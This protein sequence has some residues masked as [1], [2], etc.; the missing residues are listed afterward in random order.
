M[1]TEEIGALRALLSA[2]SARFAQDMGK[3]REA[4]NTNAAKMERGMRK[5]GDAFSWTF[6]K[7][8]KLAGYAGVGGAAGF[9]ALIKKTV[10]NTVALG[11][12][13]Q[14]IGV[15][16]RSLSTLRYAAGVTKVEFEDLADGLVTLAEAA[17]DFTEDTGPAVEAFKALKFD[18]KDANGVVKDADVLFREL[19]DKFA[20]ME[21]GALKSTLAI[22]IFSDTGK[23][24][25]PLLNMGSAGI[26]EMEERARELGFELTDNAVQSAMDLDRQFQNLWSTLAGFGTA[27]A[28]DAIPILNNLIQAMAEAYRQGGLLSGLRELILQPGRVKRAREEYEKWAEIQR[29][30]REG[31]TAEKLEVLPYK[32]VDVQGRLDAAKAALLI[33]EYDEKRFAR[34]A[35]AAGDRQREQERQRAELKKQREEQTRIYSERLQQLT[36]EEEAEKEREAAQK[37]A[38]AR[39]KAAEGQRQKLQTETVTGLQQEIDLFKATSREERVTWEIENGRFAN[40][41]EAQKKK[42]VQ[43]ARELDILDA[44]REA[45]EKL[46]NTQEENEKKAA[47]IAASQMTRQERYN[48]AVKELEN[49]YITTGLSTEDYHRRLKELQGLLETDLTGAIRGWGRDASQVL[50]DFLFAGENTFR[51]F[52]NAAIRELVRLQLQKYFTQPLFE[53]IAGRME[54]ASIPGRAAGGP[55]RA[56]GVYQVAEKGPEMLS[57]GAQHFLMMANRPG[58]VTPMDGPQAAGKQVAPQSVRIVNV[59]DQKTF[60]DW[61]SSSSGERVIVNAISRNASQIKELLS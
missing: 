42:V 53:G 34:E 3:A 35:E 29:K 51:E 57:V 36:K 41:D 6:G 40:F 48:A 30:M 13:S 55:V 28:T 45:Q 16:V 11:N 25:I 18:V 22:R 10:D 1:A 43:L 19:A 33:A 50:T 17:Q 8:K 39:A 44:I 60:D 5:V 56:G 58:M 46:K 37:A 59:L 9:A 4:L 7:L 2:S 32:L 20:G 12:M 21:D 24:L 61:G 27:I 23:Q 52:V 47:Q 38:E 15:N 54:Q 49:L 14:A 31:T 26:A